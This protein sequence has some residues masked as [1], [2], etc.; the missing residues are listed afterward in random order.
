[1]FQYR[2]VLAQ[3]RR[4]ASDRELARSHAMGRRKLAEFRALAAMQGWLDAEAPLPD[5]A[6]IAA[7]LEPAKQAASTVSSLESHRQRI[8][9]WL[10]QSVPATAILAAL[11]RNH[12][13][14]GSYSS[15]YRM[16]V[17]IR[18]ETPPAATVPLAF[19]PGEAAQVDFGAGPK[20]L[21]PDGSVRR[22]WAFVMTLCFSRHQYVE[23]VWDQTVAT[24]LGCHRR[25]F[26]WFTAVPRRLVIDNAKCAIS[27]ACIHDPVVQRAYAECAE[28]WGFRI[29]PCP[30]GDAPK[31]GIVEAGVKFVKMNFLPL[32]EFRDLADLNAQAC[33][34]VMNEAGQRVHGTTRQKPLTLFE[35]DRAH[36]LELP[37]VAP[38]LGTWHRVTVHRDC[39]VAHERAL[40]SVPFTLVGKTLWL[41]ATD[42]AVFVYH[43]HQLVATHR[44]A[45]RPGER[46][47]VRDHLPPEAQL[48]FAHDRAWCLQQAREIGTACAE[49]I[50][51]MLTDRILER[52]RAAQGVL[53]M[54]DTYGAER[55]EA[56]CA[57]ALLHASPFYRTVKT[58][59]AGG[60]DRQPLSVA[61]LGHVHAPGARFVRSAQLLFDPDAPR[62]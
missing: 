61:E 55:L 2:S 47:S 5:E 58:I 31:K 19:A 10:E 33:G 13:Y 42:T 20:L 52:L 16:I 35:L 18:G 56:A 29:D 39:H 21:H 41:R 44:R 11:K 40:Y 53:R 30:P 54:R 57:R 14:P 22:T 51:Q 7:A 38:D 48:F 8:Q 15:L 24:W 50:E 49:L 3:I 27:K 17:S 60:Y 25:A 4:G 28:G 32:R 34:W 43:E 12:G 6:Q 45:Q 46:V 23:F 26:E 37:A 1:M 36:M 62:H 59:L 9:E